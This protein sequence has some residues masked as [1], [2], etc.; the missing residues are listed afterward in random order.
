MA[1]KKT[2]KIKTDKMPPKKQC[3]TNQLATKEKN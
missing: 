2:K 1:D 3:S